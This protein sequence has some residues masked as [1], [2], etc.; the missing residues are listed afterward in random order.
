MAHSQ[1]TSYHPANPKPALSCG[2][3]VCL[4]LGVTLHGLWN[5]DRAW[6]HQQSSLPL[7]MEEG[8]QHRKKR[9]PELWRGG[10]PEPSWEGPYG[11]RSHLEPAVDRDSWP[12]GHLLA[13]TQHRCGLAT[14]HGAHRNLEKGEEGTPLPP[15]Q[16]TPSE[17]PTYSSPLAAKGD[18]RKVLGQGLLLTRSTQS[19]HLTHCVAFSLRETSATH[20]PVL[21]VYFLS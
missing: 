21:A 3:N 14:E 13:Q 6:R 5:G 17:S 16:R 20:T 1:V 12:W 4:H 10:R 7:E 2:T 8:E 19:F 18:Q 15:P 11:C 9:C